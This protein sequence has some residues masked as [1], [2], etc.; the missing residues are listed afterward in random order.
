MMQTIL[1]G[2][3]AK[4]EETE[5]YTEYSDIASKPIINQEVPA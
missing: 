3:D 5:I 1:S 4:K 2:G